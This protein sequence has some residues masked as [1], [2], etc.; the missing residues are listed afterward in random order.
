MTEPRPSAR[1]RRQDKCWD[2]VTRHYYN[3]GWRHAYK[4]FEDVVQSVVRPGQSVLDAGCGRT[5]PLA[6]FLHSL[7]ADVHGVD[8]VIDGDQVDTAGVTIHCGS[9]DRMPY[10]DGTF[11][12]IVTR[13]VMEHLRRPD[14]TLAEFHR[15]LKPGGQVAFLAPNRYDYVSVIASMVP[16]RL[17][18]WLVEAFEGREA[19]DAFPTYY[20][21]N[22]VSDIR[23]LAD[24]AGFTVEHI[25]YHN[26][27][28]AMFMTRPWLCRLGIAWDKLVSGTPSLNWLQGWLLGRLRCVKTAAAECPAG[29]KEQAA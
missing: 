3:H 26:C 10:G 20:R 7:G 8:D 25:D 13:C 9:L 18:Q 11:D 12:T 16:H 5:F 28:P 21:A 23:R 6:P 1:Q 14:R 27:Y 17:R 4:V 15:L 29:E 19:H 22:T 2:L 24:R